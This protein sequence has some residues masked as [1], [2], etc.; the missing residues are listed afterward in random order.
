MTR[1]V[2]GR[3]ARDSTMFQGAA[4]GAPAANDSGRSGG[5]GPGGHARPTPDARHRTPSEAA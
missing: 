5:S 4:A 2:L 3:T 1:A